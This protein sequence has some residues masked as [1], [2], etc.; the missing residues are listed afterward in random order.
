M[1]ASRRDRPTPGEI[2][3]AVRARPRPEVDHKGCAAA[4]MI[5]ADSAARLL[6]RPRAI[7]ASAVVWRADRRVRLVSGQHI[8]GRG[9][10]TAGPAPPTTVEPASRPRRSPRA[11]FERL[12]GA[13]RRHAPSRMARS[14][15]CKDAHRAWATHTCFRAPGHIRPPDVL[16]ARS[17]S[18][19]QIGRR[20]R[21][22]RRPQHIPR[23]CPHLGQRACQAS[24][25]GA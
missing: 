24:G 1:S 23:R 11:G 15:M 5:L 14:L 10:C 8:A 22:G 12:V 7:D 3:A 16:Q 21:S 25:Q 4:R 19:P 18:P 13:R 6:G 2:V 9:R 17:R 20:R